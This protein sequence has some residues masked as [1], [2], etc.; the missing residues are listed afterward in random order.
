[1]KNKARGKLISYMMWPMLLTGWWLVVD[2]V[3]FAINE[4][5]AW[6]SL[7]ATLVFFA[8]T[9]V[10]YLLRR[11]SILRDYVSFSLDYSDVSSQLLRER[12]V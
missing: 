2:A 1:M 7:G 8:A 12:T 11:R 9:L 5:A 4:K 10:M 6:I 3:L